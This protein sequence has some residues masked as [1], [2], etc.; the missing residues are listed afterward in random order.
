MRRRTTQIDPRTRCSTYS[1]R[2]V[3][4]RSRTTWPR[5]L[6][7]HGGTSRLFEPWGGRRSSP[8]PKRR[9]TRSDEKHPTWFPI[10]WRLDGRTAARDD[11]R[12]GPGFLRRPQD[13]R[14]RLDKGMEEVVW[15]F[16]WLVPVHC[17]AFSLGPDLASRCPRRG[18]R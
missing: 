13:T 16:A 18:P 2:K 10:V 17:W 9:P 8:G 7:S 3:S 5:S 14:P 12:F 6:R 1:E 4:P 11:P 15:R